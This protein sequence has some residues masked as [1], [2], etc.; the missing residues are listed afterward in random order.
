MCPT[1]REIAEAEQSKRKYAGS[2]RHQP[3]W[4]N[5]G[6]VGCDERAQGRLFKLVDRRKDKDVER[7]MSQAFMESQPVIGVGL[8]DHTFE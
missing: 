2:L 7:A 4:M 1:G 3:G 8:H 5:G 6:T